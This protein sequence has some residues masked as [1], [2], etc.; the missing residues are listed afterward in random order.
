MFSGGS[1]SARAV[2]RFFGR[3]GCQLAHEIGEVAR[4]VGTGAFQAFRR[5]IE[6]RR[7]GV[8]RGNVVGI[9]RRI[10]PARRIEE[11][12]QIFGRMLDDRQLLVL[13]RRN[14]AIEGQD[15]RD[16]WQLLQFGND[17]LRCGKIGLKNVNGVRFRI[18]GCASDRSA[19][20]PLRYSWRASSTD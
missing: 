19:S 2:A 17:W 11:W 12:Q 7:G 1:S 18:L 9:G 3:S 4:S 15:R 8:H 20:Q 5:I 10:D 16:L 13:I 6:L 14:K